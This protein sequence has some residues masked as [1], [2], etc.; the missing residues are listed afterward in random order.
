MSVQ[1]TLPLIVLAGGLGTRLRPVVDNCPKVLAPFGDA[2]YL[3]YFLRWCSAKG[4]SHVHLS[5]GHLAHQVVDFLEDAAKTTSL[6]LS[7]SIETQP[8]GTGGAICLSLQDTAVDYCQGVMVCNGDTFVDFEP[9]QFLALSQHKDL[10][11]LTTHV[12]DISRF[13]A[14]EKQHDGQLIHFAEKQN[15]VEAGEINAGWYFLSA[16]TCAKLIK[17]APFSFESDFLMQ[18]NDLS[19]FC[20]DLGNDFIDFGTPESYDLAKKYIGGL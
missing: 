14:I 20:L 15:R 4:I 12:E 3:A 18:S 1:I 8:L 13:G 5:L 17:T 2:P 19:I 16:S 6:T 9:K 7:W 10:T 11:L